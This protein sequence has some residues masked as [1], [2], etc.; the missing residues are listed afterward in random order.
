MSVTT[1]ALSWLLVI[2]RNWHGQMD[3]GSSLLGFFGGVLFG[4]LIMGVYVI[5]S[6]LLVSLAIALFPS[7]WSLRKL[8][9]LLFIVVL[10]S[11]VS[12]Y[13]IDPTQSRVTN[14]SA[15]YFVRFDWLASEFTVTAVIAGFIGSIIAYSAVL[16]CRR[17]FRNWGGRSGAVRNEPPPIAD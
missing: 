15:G 10:C 2:I 14:G 8:A 1:V 16:K 3:V 6:A 12:A 17:R 11:S 9:V 7:R 13:L 4:M 5:P